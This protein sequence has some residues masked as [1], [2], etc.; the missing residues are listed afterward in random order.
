MALVRWWLLYLQKYFKCS[1]LQQPSICPSN[2]NNKL[3]FFFFSAIIGFTLFSW[4]Q[5]THFGNLGFIKIYGALSCMVFMFVTKYREITSN[6]ACKSNDIWNFIWQLLDW[7]SPMILKILFCKRWSRLWSFAR[8]S[9]AHMKGIWIGP[10]RGAAR[11]RA[12]TGGWLASISWAW[13]GLDI[14]NVRVLFIIFLGG[15]KRIKK[16]SD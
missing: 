8:R 13:E 3:I 1:S 10:L 6:F 4:F 9:V 7:T 15:L 5:C 16:N 12:H 14:S 2:K 11:Q